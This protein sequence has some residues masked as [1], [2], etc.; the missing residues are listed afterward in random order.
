MRS[1]EGCRR[2]VTAGRRSG[3]GRRR[4]WSAAAGTA[5]GG[6][7]GGVGGGQIEGRPGL[8]EDRENKLVMYEY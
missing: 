1:G 3:V 2:G 5:S 8:I 6:G 7:G 4:W